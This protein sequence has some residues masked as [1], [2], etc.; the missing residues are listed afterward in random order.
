MPD[1]PKTPQ[2]AIRV[3]DHRWIAA[4][5]ASTSVGKNRSEIINALLAWYLREPGAKLPKRP[6]FEDPPSAD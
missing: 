3:P 2:R 1:Q 4:G 6:T 5:H